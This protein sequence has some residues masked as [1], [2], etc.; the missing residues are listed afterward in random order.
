MKDYSYK[1]RQKLDEFDRIREIRSTKT[2]RM[3]YQMRIAELLEII[4]NAGD[5]I[6][7]QAVKTDNRIAVNG[8]SVTVKKQRDLICEDLWKMLLTTEDLAQSIRNMIQS[9]QGVEAASYKKTDPVVSET[10]LKDAIERGFTAGYD[11]QKRVFCLSV[12]DILL[13]HR[14]ETEGWQSVRMWYGFDL[15]QALLRDFKERTGLVIK[16][17]AVLVY[18]QTFPFRNRLRDADNSEEKQV[19]DLFVRE[20]LIE[21]DGGDCLSILHMGDVSD[22]KKQGFQAFLMCA[23]DFPAWFLEHMPQEVI[24]KEAPDLSFRLFAD[25]YL[26]QEEQPQ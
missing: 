24:R 13:P 21:S 26:K 20:G 6:S 9:V 3:E 16:P 17:P 25:Q 5:S 1:T 23:K 14:K 8:Y 18:K 22:E 10:A 12:P 2:K 11:D 7:R 4:M 15:I 19:T